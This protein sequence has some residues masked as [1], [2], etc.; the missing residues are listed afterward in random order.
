MRRSQRLLQILW[1]AAVAILLVSQRQAAE[2]WAAHQYCTFLFSPL[3]P[4]P[5]PKPPGL[6]EAIK[7]SSCQLSLSL[8]SLEFLLPQCTKKADSNRG[9][10]YRCTCRNHIACTFFFSFYLP[11][12]LSLSSLARGISSWIVPVILFSCVFPIQ[13][14]PKVTKVSRTSFDR[15]YNI[16]RKILINCSGTCSV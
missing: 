3:A 7:S 16:L 12:F 10:L 5:N 14:N 15:M 2:V 6:N 9:V 8:L 1:D 11:R 4:R 13:K